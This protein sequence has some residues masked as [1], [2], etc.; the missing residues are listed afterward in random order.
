M[1]V[2][3]KMQDEWEFRTLCD[4]GDPSRREVV[5]YH[6]SFLAAM[7]AY[8]GISKIYGRLGRCWQEDREGNLTMDSGATK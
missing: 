3:G 8:P 2:K 1:S 5:R 7:R 4:F 6:F